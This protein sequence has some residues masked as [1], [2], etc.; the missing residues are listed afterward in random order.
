M[1]HSH[2]IRYRS[3]VSLNN[4]LDHSISIL[5]IKENKKV[6]SHFIFNLKPDA[7]PRLFEIGKG[8]SGSFQW[9]GRGDYNVLVSKRTPQ[10]KGSHQIINSK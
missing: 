3:L 6:P 2:S 8:K 5:E 9:R 7:L 1:N 10:D 4:G